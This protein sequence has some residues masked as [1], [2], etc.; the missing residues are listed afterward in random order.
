MRIQEIEGTFGYVGVHPEDPGLHSLLSAQ[1]VEQGRP[2]GRL[3]HRLVR[4]GVRLGE[5]GLAEEVAKRA[6]DQGINVLV[7]PTPRDHPDHAAAVFIG[8]RA[9]DIA[10]L[11]LLELQPHPRSLE[12]APAQSSPRSDEQ[13]LVFEDFLLTRPFRHEPP[14]T[15]AAYLWTPPAQRAQPLPVLVERL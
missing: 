15:V 7:T 3:L 13:P 2:A 6:K 11:G 1:L 4:N 12:D 8:R 14:L 9:A 10:D 5:L